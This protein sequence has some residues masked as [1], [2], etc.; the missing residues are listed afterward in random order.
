MFAD[1]SLWQPYLPDGVSGVIIK[2]AQGRTITDPRYAEHLHAARQRQLRWIG[3]YHFLGTGDVPAEV[4]FAHYRQVVETVGGGLRR[5][6]LVALDWE[7]NAIT[8]AP[9]A[10]VE[11][12][13]EWMRLADAHWPGRVCWYTYRALAAT[14]RDRF[15]WPLWLADPNLDGHQWA[16]RL[17]AFLL[18]Y[19]QEPVG[20]LVID[21]NKV[22]DAR[23][24]EALCGYTTE[25]D[26]DL[27]R[28]AQAFGGVVRSTPALDGSVVDE[29]V[30]N[31]TNSAGQ[32][33]VVNFREL[34]E[35]LLTNVEV[36]RAHAVADFQNG[37][38]PAGSGLSADRLA[39]AVKT[40]ADALGNG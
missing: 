5:G 10:P 36:A 25:D 13:V 4:E 7:S 23:Q 16:D 12:A 14:H 28:L 29:I 15:P 30:W 37:D 6:E 17:G 9:A 31:V 26:M 22:I 8:G 32:P 39:A 38:G 18:Q 33:L 11:H 35:F 3:H 20:G 40:F 1:V 27:G 21:V 19:G 2:A 34:A 24:L